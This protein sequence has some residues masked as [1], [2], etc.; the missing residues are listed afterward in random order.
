MPDPINEK[1]YRQILASQRGRSAPNIGASATMA[2]AEYMNYR[3]KVTPAM[4]K[5]MWPSIIATMAGDPVYA[6]KLLKNVSSPT[7]KK[8]LQTASGVAGGAGYLIPKVLSEGLK[9]RRL[10]HERQYASQLGAAGSASRALDSLSTL[11]YLMT[12]PGYLAQT[13]GLGTGLLKRIPRPEMF[14]TGTAGAAIRHGTGGIAKEGGGILASLYGGAKSGANFL[15]GG[16]AKSLYGTAAKKSPLFASAAGGLDKAITGALSSPFSVMMG[17]TAAQI[18]LSIYKSVKLSKLQPTRQM[19]DKF[20]RRLYSAQQS[21]TAMNRVLAMATRGNIDPQT[22]SFMVLQIQLGEL[23]RMNMQ[24]AGFRGEYQSEVDFIRQEKEKG[25]ESHSNA[26]GQFVL[27]E[28]DRSTTQRALDW[29]E[30]KLGRAKAKYDPVSQLI[31]WAVGL[32]QGKWILPK[33]ETSRI[34]ASYGF[35][36]ENEMIKKRAE[37]FGLATDQTRLLHMTSK[38]V[39]Q[40]APNYEAKMLAILS[41]SFDIQRLIAAEAVTI[42]S[43]AFGLEKNVL[44]RKDQSALKRFMADLGE[45]LNPFNLPGINAISNLVGLGFRAIGGIPKIAE[46]LFGGAG[47]VASSSLNWLLGEDYIKL[48]GTKELL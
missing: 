39:L 34:A 16:T 4:Q 32:T 43:G 13:A 23:Q 44:Y 12:L 7:I 19:P 15:T 29:V 36:S 5:M 45:K 9:S 28:D 6:A 20:A 38:T 1:L 33:T 35:A 18:G 24:L 31:N 2:E 17:I 40:M 11:R 22:L 14:L 21:Q 47:K 10:A 46:K 25:S 42:R 27:G 8:A 48:R 37:S 26:Y 41:A 3:Q 30:Q